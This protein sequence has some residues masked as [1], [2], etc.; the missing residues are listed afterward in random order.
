MVSEPSTHKI[1]QRDT[2]HAAT[3]VV[4]YKA[5]D[6]L[7]I[8]QKHLMACAEIYS[9]TFSTAPWNEHWTT[10]SA[11]ERLSHFYDSKGFCGAL[12]QEKAILGFVLGNIEPYYSGSIFYLREMCTSASYQNSGIGI[13][14]LDY[15]EQNLRHQGVRQI[16]LLTEQHIPAAQ[17]YQNRGYAIDE[18]C[19]SY[20]KNL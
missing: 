4:G 20:S 14:L 6:I 10:T 7:N 1:V 17:F 9:N 12:A 3:T 8:T 5:M 18:N 2:A 19:A 15:L 13:Q 16:Y 11:L